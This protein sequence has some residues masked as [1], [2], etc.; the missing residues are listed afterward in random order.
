MLNCDTL[1]VLPVFDNLTEKFQYSM[2]NKFNDLKI[3]STQKSNL[4][5]TC[6]L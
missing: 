1:L 5:Y 2:K 6:H 4:K 3:C